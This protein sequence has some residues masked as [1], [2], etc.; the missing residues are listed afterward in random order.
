MDESTCI[1]YKNCNHIDCNTFCMKKYKCDYYFNS[2]MI[3][4]DKR[5]K[6]KL[7]IDSD[8]AD[9]QAFSRLAEIERD[10]ENYIANGNNLYVY[11]NRTGNGKSSWMYRIARSYIVKTWYKRDLKPIVL[12]I[13]VP[14]FLLE[15]KANITQKSEYIDKIMSSINDCDLVI[16]DDIGSKA[17]TEFEVSHLLNIIDYR[18]ANNKSN[19]YTSNLNRDDLHQLL[20]DRLYSRIYNYSECIEF[21]GKD[22]RGI[23]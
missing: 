2:A 15:I 18:I 8:G 20:G 7:F 10:A 17:G 23:K 5:V 19:M 1:F 3:P 14:R 4:E 22:K 6:F 9:E 16:W 13:S 21:K 12:F 11:S